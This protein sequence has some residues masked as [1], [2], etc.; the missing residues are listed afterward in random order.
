M[1]HY[2]GYNLHIQDLK[3]LCVCIVCVADN[4]FAGVGNG[5]NAASNAGGSAASQTP[6]PG[7]SMMY[8]APVLPVV[9]VAAGPVAAGPPVVTVGAT[10]AVPSAVAPIAV[11]AAVAAGPPV[12]AVGATAAVPG[13]VVPV[14][15]PAAVAA[16]NNGGEGR[17]QEMCGNRADGCHNHKVLNCTYGLCGVCCAASKRD[18]RCDVTKH[19]NKNTHK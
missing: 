6:S 5:G 17:P 9:V 2:A 14:A 8:Q 15:V 7:P 10:A 1:F 4:T 19:Y 12:V 18:P 13:A 16:A 11:P 3:S